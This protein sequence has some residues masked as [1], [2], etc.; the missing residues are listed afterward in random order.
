MTVAASA[1]AQLDFVFVTVGSASYSTTVNKVTTTYTE[2]GF[3]NTGT[4]NKG[5]LSYPSEA[6]LSIGNGQKHTVK[7]IQDLGTATIR[8]TLDNPK[9][10]GSSGDNAP[11][12]GVG[13]GGESADDINLFR[14]L[15]V[16]HPDNGVHRLIREQ[17]G[18]TGVSNS[19]TS[20]SWSS[21]YTGFMFKTNTSNGEVV[22]VELRSDKH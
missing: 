5:S 1:G 4:R 11:S 13:A 2:A 18:G 17:N 8:L 6:S 9:V 19:Q 21:G 20:M 15:V 7:E 12:D 10:G 14:Q 16:H 3:S 22:I